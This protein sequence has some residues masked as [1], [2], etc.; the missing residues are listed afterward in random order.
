M[1]FED[2]IS[3]QMIRKS[4]LLFTVNT[5]NNALLFEFIRKHASWHSVQLWDCNKECKRFIAKL[6]S[7]QALSR[8][9]TPQ[10]FQMQYEIIED[11]IF[12]QMIF[13]INTQNSALQC[14]LSLFAFANML[15]GIQ[16]SWVTA[17]KNASD[18]S[19]NC[20]EIERWVVLK[21]IFPQMIKNI[22]ALPNKLTEQ[23]V[24]CCL[25]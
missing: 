4:F 23:C 18:S 5:Q 20:S 21:T 8:L 7:I 2:T 19:P 1:T 15:F 3:P 22:S 6:F 25:S 16:C 14:C 13:P 11:K 24:H 10:L 9:N 17:I 12:S